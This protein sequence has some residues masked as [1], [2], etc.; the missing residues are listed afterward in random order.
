MESAPQPLAPQD[1]DELVRHLDR[2]QGTMSFHEAHGFLTGIVS[3]PTTFML[4]AWLPM[5]MGEGLLPHDEERSADD[6]L[7]R[8]YAEIHSELNDEGIAGP[9]D[10]DDDSIADWCLGIPPRC[11]HGRRVA[12]A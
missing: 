12:G 5:I 4:S 8:L 3:A 9:L 2:A 11:T 1:L 6:L 7:V 10:D